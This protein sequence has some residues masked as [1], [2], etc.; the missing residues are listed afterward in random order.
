MY[1]LNYLQKINGVLYKS[2]YLSKQNTHIIP[3]IPKITETE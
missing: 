2:I 1:N 3:L